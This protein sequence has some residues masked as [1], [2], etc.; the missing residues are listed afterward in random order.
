MTETSL[1]EL[2]KYELNGKYKDFK[3]QQ[4]ILLGQ[5]IAIQSKVA[6]G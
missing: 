4:A 6:V 3:V 2:E 1:K 5:N